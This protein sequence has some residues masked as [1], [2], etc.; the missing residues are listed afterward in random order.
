MWFATSNAFSHLS[1]Y[2][3]EVDRLIVLVIGDLL[4]TDSLAL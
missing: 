3:S 2:P 1:I 4:Y